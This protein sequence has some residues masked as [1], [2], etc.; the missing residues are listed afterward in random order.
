MNSRERVKA[1]LLF[2]EPDRIPR[3]LWAVPYIQL[4]RKKE[5]QDILNKYPMDIGLCELSCNFTEDQLMITAKKGTWIDDWGNIWYVGEPGVFG[6]VKKPALSKWSNLAKFKPPYNLIKNRDMDSINK[7]CNESNKFMLSNI[8]A[9]PFEQLQF[10]RGTENLLLDI[11]SNSSYFHKLLKIVHEF[12]CKDIENWCKTDVDGV[13]FMDDWGTNTSLLI[14]PKIWKEIFKPLYREYCDIIH[15]YGKFAF[16][17]SDGNIEEI[18]GDLIEVGINAINCQLSKMKIE[19]LGSKYKGNFTLWGEVD[20]YI[21]AFGTPKDIYKAVMKIKS[22]F[23][24][25]CG[26]VIAQ[27]LWGKDNPKENIE[28]IYEAWN[29]V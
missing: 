20:A 16:F 19:R 8:T 22:S 25:S 15:N 24:N 4:F 1:T 17:H 5:L 2:K 29:R 13:L 10:L 6:E 21:Q 3:D 23:Y 26:G 12:F 7:R 18:F 28:A 9:R 14:N 11:A 27:S